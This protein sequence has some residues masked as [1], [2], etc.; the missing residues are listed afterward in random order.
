M[1]L[2]HCITIITLSLVSLSA[3]AA[4]L[5]I[6]ASGTGPGANDSRWQTELTLHNT[7]SKAIAASLRFH[8]AFGAGDNAVLSVPARAT[9]SVADVIKSRFGREAATGAIVVE[10]ADADAPRLTINSRTFNQSDLGEFGQDIPA[11]TL[12]EASAAG[13][14]TVLAGPSTAAAARFNFGLYTIDDVTVLWSLVRADGSIAATRQVD[15]LAG[16]QVQYNTGIST[17][18]NETPR[19]NDVVHAELTG[20]RAIFYGSAINQTTGDPSFVAGLRARGELRIDFLGVDEDEDGTVDI[21][22][23]DNDGVLDAPMDLFATAFPN[24]FRVVAIGE[25]GEPVTLEIVQPLTD[26]LVIDEQGTISYAPGGNLRG[27]TGVIQV[28][29]TSGSNSSLLTIPVRYR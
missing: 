23:A 17:F 1:S 19:D 29:A 7:G 11:F 14:L 6:P 13:D 28:R 25:N 8:D 12:D 5:I 20:G 15:Y 26:I 16:R 4:T 3:G 9:L 10:V 27:S 24:F 2:K 18:F 21:A 22:D